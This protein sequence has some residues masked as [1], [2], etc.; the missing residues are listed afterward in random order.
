MVDT[1]TQKERLLAAIRGE[2]VDITPIA[3]ITQTG[4][5]DLM[6]ATGAAWPEAHKDPEKMATLARAA[7]D[8]I[9]F[10]GIR[11]PYCLTVLLEALGCEVTDGTKTRQPSIKGHPYKKESEN[12]PSEVPDDLL[13][14]GRIPVVLESLR[15]LKSEGDGTVPIIA[16]A[17]GPITVASD[18]LEVTTFMKWSIKKRDVIERYVDYATETVIAYA[19]ALFD[20]GADVFALLDPVASPDLLSPRDFERLILPRYQD[21]SNRLKGD[22]VLHICGDVTAILPQLAE[23]GFAAISIEEKTDL[24]EAKRAFEGKTRIVGN[25]STSQT[26]FRGTPTEVLDESA[27]ALQKGTDVLAPGCGLAPT[28]PLDNCKAMVVARNDYFDL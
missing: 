21:M 4:I 23:T 19:N 22:V 9:G 27:M 10:E 6:D 16:G 2:E 1:M 28:S 12:I 25:V 11:V 20:A 8:I 7:H 26:I 17:E 14:R 5:E 15:M 13:E 18:L 24:A 3:S